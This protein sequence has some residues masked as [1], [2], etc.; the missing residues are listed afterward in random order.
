MTADILKVG[1]LDADHR[2]QALQNCFDNQYEYFRRY[3]K[4]YIGKP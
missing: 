3:E 4:T 1:Q 2:K